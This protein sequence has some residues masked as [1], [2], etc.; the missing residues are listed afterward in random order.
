M[1]A[2]K[3]KKHTRVA[4]IDGL[5]GVASVIVMMHHFACALYPSIIFGTRALPHSGIEKLIATT[6][7]NLFFAGNF[8]VCIFFVISG[9]VL[10]RKFF[11]GTL[12]QNIVVRV[13]RRYTR[14]MVPVLGSFFLGY[15]LMKGNLFFN[16]RIAETTHSQGWLAQ[17]YNFPPSFLGMLK[18][19]FFRVFLYTS[20]GK[21]NS[22]AWSISYEFG[23]SL[24]I[25]FI[26]AIFSGTVKRSTIY[27]ALACIF[28]K[29]YFLGF[30]LGM[31]AA[32]PTNPFARYTG[33]SLRRS[34]ALIIFFIALFLGSY[35]LIP[36]SD[37]MYAFLQLPLISNEES[38][39][40]Y[41]TIAAFIL[42]ICIPRM[43]P[44]VSLLTGKPVLWMGKISVS[45]FLT[46]LLI[47]CSASS[48]I[49]FLL[50]PFAGYHLAAGATVFISVPIIIFSAY[51]FQTYWIDAVPTMYGIACS[52]W[53]Y[54]LRIYRY[55]WV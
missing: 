25:F 1:Q 23:G 43:K 47:L 33:K 52:R 20:G 27:A 2:M 37:T 36:V 26:L 15:L 53:L 21:Y 34:H 49:F 55:F 54:R 5:R 35:P 50:Y 39:V 44:I 7:L 48:F 14:L 22:V 3:S 29:T 18:Q 45:V 46:H 31:M 17:Q 4:Y 6:P 30:V 24:L 9:Y 42:I 38:A 8:A 32:D 28:W 40:F 10:S 19:S 41:H 11:A 12:H 13:V 16:A 51:C